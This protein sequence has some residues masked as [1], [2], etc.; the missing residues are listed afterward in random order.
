MRKFCT[1]PPVLWTVLA[2]VACGSSRQSEELRIKL[3]PSTSTITVGSSVVIN[4]QTSPTLPKNYGSLT[5][6]VK[7]FGISCSEAVADPANAPQVPGCSSGW[8]AYAQPGNGFTPTVVYYHAATI[9]GSFTV[10]V[11]GVITDSSGQKIQNVGSAAALVT[12]KA[13]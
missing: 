4:A 7:G 6:M 1:L 12:V 11:N 2:M 8:L 10:M 9:P 13:Q 5:W 3:A